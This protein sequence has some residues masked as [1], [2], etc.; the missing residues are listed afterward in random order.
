MTEGELT[1][2]ITTLK[3]NKS[4]GSDTSYYTPHSKLGFQEKA[5]TPPS[6]KEVMI[7]EYQKEANIKWKV[8]I[9]DQYLS[10]M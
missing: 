8:G 2:A 10:L 1:I 5:Q 7:S 9:L 3:L 6:W 4:P